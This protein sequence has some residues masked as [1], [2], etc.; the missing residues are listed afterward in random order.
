MQE[1]TLQIFLLLAAFTTA[2]VLQILARPYKDPRSNS[3][4]VFGYSA[5]LLMV[6]AVRACSSFRCTISLACGSVV[7]VCC[8]L[9]VLP[10][11]QNADIFLFA[12]LATRCLDSQN[13]STWV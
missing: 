8:S 2:L 9:V 13:R 6:R 4:A 7:G 11:P 5:L 10:V 3:L 12:V 1:P